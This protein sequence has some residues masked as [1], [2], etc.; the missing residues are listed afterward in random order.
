MI[1]LDAS[2][3][4]FLERSDALG[5]WDWLVGIYLE[6]KALPSV[7]TIAEARDAMG[8]YSWRALCRV[9][10]VYQLW[11]RESVDYLARMLVDVGARTVLEVGAG[12]GRLTQSLAIRLTPLGVSVVGQDD[13]S[14]AAMKGVQPAVC[15]LRQESIPESLAAVAPDTVLVSW[16]PYNADWSPWFRDSASVERYIFIGEDRYGCTGTPDLWEPPDGWHV[17]E[18]EGFSETAASRIDTSVG[19]TSAWM[20][21]RNVGEMA[22]LS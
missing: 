8:P 20:V 9:A 5:W 17:A 7:S 4:G 1:V 2:S 13:G 16:M 22:T 11:T 15:A 6:A 21:S 12:D 10:T 19:E 14:W 3:K 18:C